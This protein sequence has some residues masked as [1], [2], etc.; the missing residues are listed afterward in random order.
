MDNDSNL[1]K[2]RG[3]NDYTMQQSPEESIFVLNYGRYT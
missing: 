3:D 2:L 1:W